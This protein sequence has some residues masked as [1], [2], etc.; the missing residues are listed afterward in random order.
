MAEHVQGHPSTHGD[1]YQLNT[2]NIYRQAV[3]THGEQEIAHR[4]AAGTW[5]S[6]TYAETW[7]RI[8]RTAN[9]LVGLGVRPG[10]VVG[11]LDWN[12]L[13]HFELYWAIPGTGAV[14]LQMNLR[15]GIDDL[16]YV[17]EHSGAAVV[18]VDESLLSQAEELVERCPRVRRWVVMSDRPLS[19]ISTTLPDPVEHEALLAESADTFAWPV[20]SETSAYSACYTTGTTGRP[21]GVFYSHRGIVLH[22]MMWAADQSVTDRD[23]VLLTT[24]MF[25]AQ[26]WGLPQV[27]VQARS[28]IVLPGRYSA[29][30]IHILAD[31]MVQFD[32]TVTNGAPA[33][34]A[35]M[36]DHLRSLDEAPDLSRLRMISGSTEPPLS[37]MRGY[38]ELTGAR[39]I[40]GYGATETTPLV[41]SNRVKPSLDGVLDEEG[42]WDLK[43]SQGLP[44]AGVDLRLLG[45]DGEFLPHDG[46]CVGEVCIRG[47]WITESYWKVDPNPDQFHRGYWRSGDIG[48]ISP[49]GYLKITDRL[50]DVIKSGG[51]WISSI[52]LENLLLEHP[53]VHEAAV[54]GAPH[55]QWQERPLALV[56]P[57]PGQDPDEQELRAHLAK[58]FA[59]WQLP[60]Q[61]LIVASLPRTGVGKVDKK[62][63]R[64]AHED[65]YS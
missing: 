34:F 16:A 2:T 64:A 25:H 41:T 5:H 63:L 23:T 31:A 3:T 57:A 60:D 40:H 42:L 17:V 47:P 27:G 22:T 18:C 56:V 51:E 21:K 53:Q 12:H 11:I 15:L 6:T 24:P 26:C 8:N 54:I 19:E 4:D 9:V 1:S 44:V 46:A 13:R 32:V 10:D 43:R 36:L 58:R 30:E 35:P 52:D 28:R 49:E 59:R 29:E 33:I 45:P 39:I 37:L 50:K 7:A 65:V 62:S 38:E 20:I 61:I 48:A 14:M 55:A